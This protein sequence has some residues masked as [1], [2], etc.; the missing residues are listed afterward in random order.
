MLVKKV[1]YLGKFGSS[2]VIVLEKSIV[3]EFLEK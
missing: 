2:E 1:T 3:F